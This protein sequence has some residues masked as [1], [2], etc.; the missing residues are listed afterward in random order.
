MV[1]SSFNSSV[2]PKPG[3][4]SEKPF[5]GLSPSH[6]LSPTDNLLPVAFLLPLLWPVNILSPSAMS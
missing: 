1:L 6:F 3:S 5:P 4:L 2:F